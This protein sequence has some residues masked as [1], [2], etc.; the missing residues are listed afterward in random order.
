MSR[1][2]A[3]RQAFRIKARVESDRSRLRGWHAHGSR[4]LLSRRTL[5]QAATT[6]LRSRYD[7]L[8]NVIQLKIAAGTSMKKT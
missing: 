8:L 2:Q 6:Y 4:R 3:L 7:Y 5:V 1:V